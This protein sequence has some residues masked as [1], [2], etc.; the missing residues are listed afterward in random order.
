[1][2]LSTLTSAFA[3]P[4]HFQTGLP[5]ATNHISQSRGLVPQVREGVQ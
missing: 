3:L 1:L 5:E 2:S 4:M